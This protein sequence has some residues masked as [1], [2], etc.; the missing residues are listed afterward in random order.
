MPDCIGCAVVGLGMMGER[1]A[2]IWAELP[3]TRLVS[4]YDV[5]AQRSREIAAR[6]DCRQ[7]ASLAEVERVE[8]A[9]RGVVRLH[10][11]RHILQV[12][13][14]RP[15]ADEIAAHD[16]ATDLHAFDLPPLRKRLLQVGDC[17]VFETVGSARLGIN[18]ILL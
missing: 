17:L 4:V 6:H 18:I 8:D 16:H 1:H 3:R 11:R 9:A 2:R 12:A 7:A 14:V 10:E 13:R 5:V 15:A